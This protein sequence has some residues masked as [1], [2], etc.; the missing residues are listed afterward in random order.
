MNNV[1]V[2]IV[3][4]ITGVIFTGGIIGYLM[5]GDYSDQHTEPEQYMTFTDW[6]VEPFSLQ[7]VGHWLFCSSSFED[8]SFGGIVL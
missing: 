4:Y 7:F 2:W 1:T 5:Y 3:I 6:L 8:C